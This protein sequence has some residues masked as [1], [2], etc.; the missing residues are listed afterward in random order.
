MFVILIFPKKETLWFKQIFI[1]TGTGLVIIMRWMNKFYY[2]TI[3]PFSAL[4]DTD[5]NMII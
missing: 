4:G 3:G 2:S 1:N 5:T